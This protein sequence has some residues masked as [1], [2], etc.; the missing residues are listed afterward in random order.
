MNPARREASAHFPRPAARAACVA[1]A[2][3][4]VAIALALPAPA[5]ASQQSPEATLSVRDP[6]G[7]AAELLHRLT[8]AQ[9]AAVLKTTPAR[10][11]LESEAPNAT[12]SAELAELSANPVATLAEVLD[13]LA[14]RGVSTT[15]LELAINRLLA[16]AGDS[17]EQLRGTIGSALSDLSQSGH[18]GALASEL[19]LPPAVVEAAH[20]APSTAEHLASALGTNTERL[21]SVLRAAGAASRPLAGRS[22]L[23]AGNIERIVESGETAL[24]GMPSGEG[25]LSLTTINSTNVAGAASAGA[26][27]SNAFTIISIRVT[28]AGAIQETVRVPGPGRVAINASTQKRVA[29]RSRNARTRSFTRRS[30]LASA[31]A[32]VSGGVRTFTLRLKRASGLPRLVLVRLAT[33]YTPT[34]GSANTIQRNVAVTRPIAR[35]RH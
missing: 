35:R 30:T 21:S 4:A 18:I 33:T 9:A 13:L 5:A 28:K 15:P 16:G 3:P 31:A 11:M 12:V 8:L 6:G 27:V 34:G 7:K 23:V 17:A 26:G 20:L 32:P 19:G 2:L 22:P 29:L 10:L 24:V 14:A 25:G 1:L